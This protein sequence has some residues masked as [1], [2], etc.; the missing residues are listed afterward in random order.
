MEVQV[1][2]LNGAPGRDEKVNVAYDT[3]T[4]AATITDRDDEIR[5]SGD[6]LIAIGKAIEAA[7]RAAR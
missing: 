4:G 1:P 7:R 5:V 2:D 6:A 3:Q